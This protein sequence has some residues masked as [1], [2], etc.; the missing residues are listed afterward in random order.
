[1]LDEHYPGTVIAS[2]IVKS[3]PGA[4]VFPECLVIPASGHPYPV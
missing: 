2:G 3:N 1:M 4:R